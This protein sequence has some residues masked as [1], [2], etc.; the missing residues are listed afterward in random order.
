FRAHSNFGNVFAELGEYGRAAEEQREALRLF[1]DSVGPYANLAN[2]LLALQ[3]FDEAL[4][5]VQQARVRKLDDAVLR[6]D[7]YALAVLR[8]C[9]GGSRARLGHSGRFCAGRFNGARTQQAL[10]ARHA[11]AV[12]MAARHSGATSA[13]PQGC[14]PG[15]QSPASRVAADRI[16]TNQFRR[17]YL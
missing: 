3:Q 17:Q 2:A 16:R 9:A 5:T 8:G 1:P 10:S 13:K 4:Q 6:N 14:G 11:G 15:D 12:P 7:L